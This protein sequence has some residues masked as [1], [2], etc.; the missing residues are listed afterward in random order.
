MQRVRCMTPD[1]LWFSK[2]WCQSLTPQL[3]GCFVMARAVCSTDVLLR[4][5]CN[6]IV[7]WLSLHWQFLI[8]LSLGISCWPRPLL[9]SIP[10][11]MEK[12]KYICQF[13]WPRGLRRRSAA[14]R[15]LRLGVR[16]PSG[17]WMSVSCECRVLSGR[18]L[19]DEMI[20]RPEE[21][22]RLWCVIVCDLVTSRMRR[23]CPVLGH[24]ATQKKNI[25]VFELHMKVWS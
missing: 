24:S 19:S 23:P 17:A 16:I 11:I 20:T 25:Y 6:F 5:E 15:L 21:S 3:C 14:A 18:S 8:V 22:C 9:S 7:T 1:M 12:L 2:S 4:A 10:K 13:Q